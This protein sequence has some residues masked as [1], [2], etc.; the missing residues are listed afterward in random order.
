MK[1]KKYT[2]KELMDML[3][4]ALEIGTVNN[5]DC[6]IYVSKTTIKAFEEAFKK[7]TN[8]NK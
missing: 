5:Y 4:M 6:T 1:F 8:G 7:E 2:E 3:D